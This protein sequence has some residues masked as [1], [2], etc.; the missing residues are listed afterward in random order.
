VPAFYRP[1]SVSGPSEHSCR[2]QQISRN[3]SGHVTCSG[4]LG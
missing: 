3:Q 1:A 2:L 4:S